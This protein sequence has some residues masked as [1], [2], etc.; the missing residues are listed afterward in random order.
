[1]EHQGLSQDCEQGAEHKQL[2][3]DAKMTQRD[4]LPARQPKQLL[5]VTGDLQA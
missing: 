5:K 2:W 4:T 3:Q 1:V